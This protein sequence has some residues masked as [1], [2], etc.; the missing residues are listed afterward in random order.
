MWH[1]YV[2]SFEL[3]DF[4]HKIRDVYLN[5]VESCAEILQTFFNI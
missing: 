5:D 1:K 2:I 4:F 3:Y